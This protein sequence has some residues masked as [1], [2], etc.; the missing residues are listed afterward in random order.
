MT[1]SLQG[2]L[3]SF[4]LPDVLSFLATTRKSG[5][6]TLTRGTHTSYVFFDAGA[7]V[8]AGSNQEDLRLSAIL[9]RKKRISRSQFEAIDALMEKEGGRFGQLAI[10]QRILSEDQ[11]RDYLKVQVSEIIY[12]CFVWPDGAFTFVD[13]LTLP[14]YA[15]TIAV[16]LSNLIMEGARR[17]EEWEQCLQLL[18][19]SS[20]VYRVVSNPD[21][22]EKITLSRDEWKIL[23]LINGQRTL[24]ELC[25]TAEDEPF[26]VYRVVYG[27]FAN[28]LIEETPHDISISSDDIMTSIVEPPRAEAEPDESPFENTPPPPADETIR[29]GTPT[30]GADS[31]M[32]E[33]ADDTQLLVSKEAKLT[34]RDLV[35][36]TVAQ[37]TFSNGEL[38]GTVVPLIESEYLVGR[39]SENN[40][41]IND[42]GVSGFHARIFRG[43]D[44]YV[45]EDLKSR[46]GTWVNGG[47]VYHALLK[48]GDA[49][50]FGATEFKY[51]LLAT[52][53]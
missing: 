42:L 52:G 48:D 24:E 17:I 26:Q 28:K 22:D 2:S 38:R 23:F 43:P 36:P 6:L 13:E 45:V 31:T 46:N 40:I 4:K 25:H 33:Q 15:V 1:A 16:D 41:A 50:R 8:Y 9:L 18:P 5:T 27:L 34:Y 51:E 47:V 44:G 53:T 7:V 29:Q 39:R 12:D 10:Q 30:F 35:K 21:K 37:L 3:H 14:P 49:L 19:D 11:L 20:V 32:R